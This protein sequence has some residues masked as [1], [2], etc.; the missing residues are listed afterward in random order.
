MNVKRFAPSAPKNPLSPPAGA[1]EIGSMSL[2]PPACG[3][4]GVRH[5]AYA[6]SLKDAQ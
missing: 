6:Y 3:G 1:G 5:T 4:K 2:S